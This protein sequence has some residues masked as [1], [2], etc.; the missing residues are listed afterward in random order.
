MH[1]VSLVRPVKRSA[2]HHRRRES[3]RVVSFRQRS[4]PKTGNVCRVHLPPMMRQEINATQVNCK[5]QGRQLTTSVHKEEK[6]KKSCTNCG[7]I[8][9]LFWDDTHTE[10]AKKGAE[11]KWRAHKEDKDEKEIESKQQRKMSCV[12][13]EKKRERES[14]R[15]DTRFAWGMMMSADVMVISYTDTIRQVW[16][17]T[18]S[19]ML[20]DSSAFL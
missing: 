12:K 10:K 6:E 7:R 8:A 13:K 3:E 18:F 9:A 14:D 1:L 5:R 19:A 16:L 2:H 11:W 17:A 15:R 20:T 4:A